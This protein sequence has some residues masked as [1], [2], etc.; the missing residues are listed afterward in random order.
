MLIKLPIIKNNKLTFDNFKLE[1]NNNKI[2]LNTLDNINYKNLICLNA[3][4]YKNMEIY[5]PLTFN[6]SN[7]IINKGTMAKSELNVRAHVLVKHICLSN[8]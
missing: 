3:N 8:V 4:S 7:N 6:I 2:I 1:N 5:F